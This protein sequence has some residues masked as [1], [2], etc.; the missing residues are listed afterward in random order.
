M[1][2]C[3]ICVLDVDEC[4]YPS[5]GCKFQCKNLIGSFMCI[6]P[7]GYKQIGT[8]DNCEDVDECSSDS[9]L[10]QNGDCINLEGSYHCRCYTGFEISKDGKDCIGRLYLYCSVNKQRS[11]RF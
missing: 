2:V 5:N 10:C 7:P 4:A 11:L 1:S 3:V 8:A 9:G 6:C